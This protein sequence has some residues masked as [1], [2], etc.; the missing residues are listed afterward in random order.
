MIRLVN[1]ARI[2]GLTPAMMFGVLV[3]ERGFA[4]YGFDTEITCGSNGTHSKGSEH[5]VGNAID[6]RIRHVPITAQITVVQ[7]IKDALGDDFDVILESDHLHI[8]YDPK[9]PLN[10]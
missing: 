10:D 7:Y 4:K 2:F 9:E 5:Y 1:R 8:E 6:F 3:A